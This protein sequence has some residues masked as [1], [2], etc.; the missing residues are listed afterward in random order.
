MVT[1]Q[2]HLPSWGTPDSHLRGFSPKMMMQGTAGLLQ[3]A[4]FSR[5]LGKVCVWLGGRK[6]PR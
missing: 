4:F 6:L 1:H 5:W 3:A 2:L